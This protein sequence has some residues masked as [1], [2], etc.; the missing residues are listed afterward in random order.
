MVK[1]RKRLKFE[2]FNIIYKQAGKMRLKWL[3]NAMD[4][5]LLTLQRESDIL[6]MRFTDITTEVTSEQEVRILQ[7]IQQKTEK[8]GKSAHIKIRI[9]QKLEVVIACCRTTTLSSPF[10]ISR[11]PQ[12]IYKSKVKKHHTQVLPNYL[13][14]KFAE[15]R[16]ATRLFDELS[17]REKPTFHE[18]R[19]LGVKL[20]E[21]TGCDAQA[22]AGHTTRQ[23]TEYYK[24]GHEIEWTYADSV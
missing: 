15:V 3:Q 1:Q 7:V 8:H 4:I 9:S 16:D 23:M 19:S 12:K 2:A 20:Y 18:I 22:L 17:A 21:D 14:E 10:L 11:Q 13:C 24:K 6:R 5:G